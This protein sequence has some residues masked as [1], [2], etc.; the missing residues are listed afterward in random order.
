[1]NVALLA[2]HLLMMAIV[3]AIIGADAIRSGGSVASVIGACAMVLAVQLFAG[4]LA[5]LLVRE[6]SVSASAPV[7]FSCSPSAA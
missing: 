7:E 1:M 3:L 4:V 5:L 2:I 6:P